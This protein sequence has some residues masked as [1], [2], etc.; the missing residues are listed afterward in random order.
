MANMSNAE[1]YDVLMLGSGEA[2]KYLAWHFGSAGKR[3]AVIER[4]YIGGSCP[5]IACLPSKNIIHSAKVASL[6]QRSE[7]YGITKDNWKVNMSSVRDRKSK[8]VD[9]LVRV[10]LDRYK[11]SGVEL[12]LG[13][14]RFIQPKTIE[15]ALTAGGSRTLRGELVIIS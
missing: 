6:F 7:E 13:Q 4:K 3:T 10:H 14:G 1:Q 15:V 8:M 12:V 11:A 9:K 5:N 2:G